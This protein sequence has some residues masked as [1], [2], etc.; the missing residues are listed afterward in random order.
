MI[1]TRSA[2]SMP[3]RPLS[4]SRINFNNASSPR[5]QY[6]IRCSAARPMP[7]SSLR[8]GSLLE[9]Q[10]THTRIQAEALRS[11]IHNSLSTLTWNVVNRFRCVFSCF[12]VIC[13]SLF[14]WLPQ[15]PPD[16]CALSTA[17]FTR[18]IYTAKSTSSFRFFSASHF[19]PFLFTEKLHHF[20]R[21]I[22]GSR[23]VNRPIA[24]IEEQSATQRQTLRQG[25]GQ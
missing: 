14:Y 17:L 4:S 13:I 12:L 7:W 5:I 3:C 6:S 8:L 21:R 11:V 25:K 10:E 22:A 18:A 20:Y 15:F 9:H 24:R 2:F 1:R 23:S 16:H 19:P